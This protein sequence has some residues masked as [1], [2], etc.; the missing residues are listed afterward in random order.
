MLSVTLLA[1]LLR[2][3]HTKLLVNHCIQTHLKQFSGVTLS[4]VLELRDTGAYGFLLPADQIIPTAEETVAMFIEVSK[5]LS[6]R[7]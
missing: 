6:S 2:I 5:E 7:N 3:I 4:W 1:E